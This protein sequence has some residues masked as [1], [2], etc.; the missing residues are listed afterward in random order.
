[1]LGCGAG[2][3][4]AASPGAAS[5]NRRRADADPN[6]G[7]WLAAITTRAVYECIEGAAEVSAMLADAGVVV[8]VALGSSY[9]ADRAGARTAHERRGLPFLEVHVATPHE[10]CER[11]DPKGVY[12]G[13][14]R[15]S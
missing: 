8:L 12:G 14:E 13:R 6:G 5:G 9:R 10:E 15:A 1:M 7:R 2:S 4:V 3:R 11:R